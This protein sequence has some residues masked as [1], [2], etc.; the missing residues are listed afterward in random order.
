MCLNTLNSREVVV[1][2]EE[3]NRYWEKIVNTMND[4]L[5]LVGPD[6]RIIMV[7]S[8]LESLLG[9]KACELVGRPCTILYSDACDA[10]LKISVL[11]VCGKL[12]T[13]KYTLFYAPRQKENLSLLP[14]MQFHYIKQ[15][16]G[17]HGS[18]RQGILK[19][20]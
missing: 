15:V 3:L 16:E 4:G 10:T 20:S 12:I 5:F 6:G 1:K 13:A 7:N 2:A 8:A 11:L 9:Y 14:S 17:Q 18:K 19:K